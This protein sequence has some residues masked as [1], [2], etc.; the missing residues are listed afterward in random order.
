MKFHQTP[1]P[2]R[3]EHALSH[4]HDDDHSSAVLPEHGSH[5]EHAQRRGQLVERFHSERPSYA[6]AYRVHGERMH[7]FRKPGT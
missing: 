1:R 3:S 7:L 2:L 4:L 5:S 6:K